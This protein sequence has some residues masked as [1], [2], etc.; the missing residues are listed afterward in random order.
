MCRVCI[1][2]SEEAKADKIENEVQRSKAQVE[3]L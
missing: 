3:T 1:F 2:F